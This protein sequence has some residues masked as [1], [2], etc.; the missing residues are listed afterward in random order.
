MGH[1]DRTHPPP[2]NSPIWEAHPGAAPDPPLQPEGDPAPFQPPVGARGGW[3]CVPT[4]MRQSRQDPMVPA[5][6]QEQQPHPHASF[7][8]PPPAPPTADSRTHLSTTDTGREG[9][10]L[11]KRGL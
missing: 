1:K 11:R 4:K 2:P 7:P 9:L 6:P 8:S 5:V 3:S 10:L